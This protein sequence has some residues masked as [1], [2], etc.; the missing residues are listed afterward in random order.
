[1]AEV[2]LRLPC[3][4][5]IL[6]KKGQL[7][8]TPVSRV[9]P[10]LA[11]SRSFIF[12]LIFHIL[13]RH[14]TFS[15]FVFILQIHPMESPLRK[16]LINM[17]R[18]RKCPERLHECS[19][20]C[21][22]VSCRTK[23]LSGRHQRHG[24]VWLWNFWPQ[25]AKG[26]EFRKTEDPKVTPFRRLPHGRPLNSPS[27]RLLCFTHGPRTPKVWETQWLP[28]LLVEALSYF[29]TNPYVVSTTR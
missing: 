20:C 18:K 1:M 16:N 11:R 10:P 27:A 8:V 26:K 22:V 14:P 17:L 28:R 29:L 7:S 25:W 3:L 21:G 15:C 13:G 19:S 2:G 4:T 23:S 6:C 12:L 5:P 24:R 9:W